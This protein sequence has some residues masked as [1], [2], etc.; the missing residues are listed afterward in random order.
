MRKV[1][2]NKMRE[3]ARAGKNT[4]IAKNPRV[5]TQQNGEVEPLRSTARKQKG[6]DEAKK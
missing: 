1:T 5:A 3:D 4:A 2:G 6:T